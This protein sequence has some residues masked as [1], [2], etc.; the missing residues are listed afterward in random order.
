MKIQCKNILLFI[1]AITV[2][3]LNT[4]EFYIHNDGT[5]TVF[6]YDQTMQQHFEIMPKRK[7][8][9]GDPEKHAHCTV[10]YKSSKD[11]IAEFRMVACATPGMSTDV[12]ITELLEGQVPEIFEN[13]SVEPKKQAKKSGCSACQAR[14]Q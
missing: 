5:R 14:R 9:I 12:T 8:L 10:Y 11:K 3:M 6:V 7:V 2:S 1:V 4:C 13:I